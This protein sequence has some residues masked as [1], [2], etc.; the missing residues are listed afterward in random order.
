MTVQPKFVTGESVQFVS[1]ANF[2]NAMASAVTAVSIVTTDGPGGR[3]GITVSAISSVSAEPPMLLACIKEDSPA[4]AAIE[5]NKNFC[6]N[7]LSSEQSDLSNRFAGRP[8]NGLPYDFDEA[9]WRT[10]ATSAPVLEGAAANFDCVLMDCH[11]VGTHRIIFGLVQIAD[12]TSKLPLAYAQRE[13][14]LL[15]PLEIA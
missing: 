3:F 15:K 9:N 10:E 4:I 1:S 14:Q 11:S 12:H 2:I 7:V 13:Y 8:H 6:V 5:A